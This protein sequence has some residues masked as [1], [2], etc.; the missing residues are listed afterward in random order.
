MFSCSVIL[1]FVTILFLIGSLPLKAIAFVV[2]VEVLNPYL[3]VILFSSCIEICSASSVIWLS[4]NEY[5]NVFV[6]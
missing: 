5:L 2:H 4:A 3:G 6:S 1:L